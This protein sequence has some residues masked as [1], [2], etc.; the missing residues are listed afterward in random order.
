MADRPIFVFVAAYSSIADATDDYNAVK[1][2][3]K[4]GLIGTYDSAL[5]TKDDEGK[6]HVKQTEKPTEH[7]VVAGAAAGAIIGAFFPPALLVEAGIGALTGGVIQHLR[8][9]LPHKDLKELGDTFASGTAAIV[10]VGESKIDEA[11]AKAVKKS[12]KTIEKQ[13]NADAKE[14]NKD[15][16]AAVKASEG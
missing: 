5:V 8:K 1:E 7:G 12:I 6:V 10:V 11:V 3:H 14:F 16:E 2:L 15:L 4:A 13:V 9:G